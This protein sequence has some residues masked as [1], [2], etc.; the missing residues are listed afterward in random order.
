[1][2]RDAQKNIS[3]LFLQ[4]PAVILGEADLVFDNVEFA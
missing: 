4:G 3:A 1:V 2:Q